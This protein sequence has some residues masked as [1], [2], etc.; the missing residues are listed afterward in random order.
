MID[1]ENIIGSCNLRDGDWSSRA[2]KACDFIASACGMS[3]A[4]TGVSDDETT[5][6][7]YYTYGSDMGIRMEYSVEAT[8]SIDTISMCVTYKDAD[9]KFNVVGSSCGSVG[10]LGVGDFSESPEE[11]VTLYSTRVQFGSLTMTRFVRNN[12]I[13]TFNF[14]P[15]SIVDYFS[16]KTRAGIYVG[17]HD[18]YVYNDADK[19]IEVMGEV[20]LGGNSYPSGRGLK[21]AAPVMLK[22]PSFYG[23]MN[24]ASCLYH[25]SG[26]STSYFSLGDKIQIG[27]VTFR[28]LRTYWLVRC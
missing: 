8:L 1:G 20:V 5:I 15:F 13:A 25:I 14:M 6:Y 18:C 12:A 16:S 9:G 24:N 21:V 4:G 28:C 27:G 23:Y 26:V 3:P 22:S 19:L 7:R 17:G 11:N 2:P 10:C